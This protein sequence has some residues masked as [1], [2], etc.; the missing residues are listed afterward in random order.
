[1]LVADFGSP[2]R[3]HRPA[4]PGPL[5]GSESR[6]T[7]NGQAKPSAEERHFGKNDRDEASPHLS[8]PMVGA[9]R[10][11]LCRG[12]NDDWQLQNYYESRLAIAAERNSRL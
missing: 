4:P 12:Q 11:Q 8:L 5:P 6:V 9:D 1:M 2:S 10:D 3:P 7:L